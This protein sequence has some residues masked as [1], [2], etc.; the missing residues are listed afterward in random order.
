[1]H[2]NVRYFFQ[3]LYPSKDMENLP[4]S[5]SKIK[6]EVFKS[7]GKEFENN[8]LKNDWKKNFTSETKLKLQDEFEII[9]KSK[10]NT[11]PY[12][13][14]EFCEKSFK[15]K[16]QMQR[17]VKKVHEKALETKCALC[18]KTF[19]DSSCLQVHMNTFHSKM[20]N[21]KCDSC[22][23]RFVSKGALI[24]HIQVRHEKTQA[25]KCDTCDKEFTS[26][27]GLSHHL[28]N[29]HSNLRYKCYLC[30]KTFSM[31]SS[32]N[33]HFNLKHQNKDEKIKCDICDKTV[34]DIGKHKNI[35]HTVTKRHPCHICGKDYSLKFYVK[36]QFMKRLKISN[37]K[38]VGKVFTMK[39]F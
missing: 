19:S 3:N 1:M 15:L 27:L 17:H 2:C 9:R 4:M 23:Q 14:C 20:K 22:D 10:N 35:M 7:E 25:S 33:K 36:R 31:K 39:E 29:V 16:Y 30:V 34:S 28:E 37:A 13:N 5:K 6:T 18:E 32:L 11:K 8:I 26:K 21:F 24:S 38:L 12:S